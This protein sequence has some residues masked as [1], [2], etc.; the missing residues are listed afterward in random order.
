MRKFKDDNCPTPLPGHWPAKVWEFIQTKLIRSTT[1]TNPRTKVWYL[2]QNQGQYFDQNRLRPKLSSLLSS[3]TSYFHPK[4]H[5]ICH[6]WL[7]AYMPL[8]FGKYWNHRRST[9]LLHQLVMHLRRCSY[10][11]YIVSFFANCVNF[12]WK[13]H[14]F[15]HNN[16]KHIRLNYLFY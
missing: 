5:Q 10:K 8:L 1:V 15:L 14:I 6:I 16:W 13:Q 2:D 4:N 3:R 12:S 7:M 9:C 11:M